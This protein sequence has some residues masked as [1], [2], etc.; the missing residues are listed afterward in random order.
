MGNLSRVL[1]KLFNKRGLRM[2][3]F[4]ASILIAIKPG[5]YTGGSFEVYE[6]MYL[7]EARVG[8]GYPWAN[9]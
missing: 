1:S 8:W 9:S 5:N 7:L 4:T 6:D 2:M 3:W